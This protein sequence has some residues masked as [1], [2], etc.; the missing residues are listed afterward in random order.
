MNN[1]EINECLFCR[2]AKKSLPTNVVF[3]NENAIAFLDILPRTPG[4]TLIVPK[5]HVPTILELEDGEIKPLFDAVQEVAKILTAK[6]GPDGFTIGINQ[7][8]ASGQLV[9]HLHVH[10]MPRFS[11]DRGGSIHSVVNNPPHTS[12]EEMIA[13]IKE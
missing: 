1:T 5:R 3:E 12:I 13:K 2:I 10:V 11:G 8:S 6:I 7:G 9:D 4:H